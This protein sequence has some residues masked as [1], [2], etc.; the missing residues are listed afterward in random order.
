MIESLVTACLH[1]VNATPSRWYTRRQ[2]TVETATFG[3]EFVAAII[4]TDQIIDLRY[5]FEFPSDPKAICLVTTNLWLTVQV[6]LSK[7][8]TLVS[9]HRVREAIAAGYLQF[10]WKDGKSNPVD[11]LSKHW[12]FTSIWPLL[13]PLLFWKGDTHELNDK[14]KGSDRIPA[15]RAGSITNPNGQRMN[16]QP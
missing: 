16:Q 4:A 5:T 7:K 1:L 14:T 12:E 3:S 6:S 8:S 15:K 11:I 13:K 2:A 9:Y 10:N